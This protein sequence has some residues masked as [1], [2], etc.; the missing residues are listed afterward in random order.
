MPILIRQ[1][2]QICSSSRALITT[3]GGNGEYQAHVSS[4]TLMA[5]PIPR[6]N[7]SK[8]TPSRHFTRLPGSLVP[9]KLNCNPGS[10][11]SRVSLVDEEG[12]TSKSESCV[13]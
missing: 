12:D 9:W 7:S 1:C 5:P 6:E 10:S 4:L 3:E 8:Q 13:Y 2:Q 11:H